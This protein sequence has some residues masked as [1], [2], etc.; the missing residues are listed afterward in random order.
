[1]LIEITAEKVRALF[2]EWWKPFAIVLLAALLLF[3]NARENAQTQARLSEVATETHSALCVF[4]QS[5]EDRIQTTEDY[6]K[7]HPGPEPIPG[8]TR[9]DLRRSLDA[10]RQTLEALS[11]LDCTDIQG[12]E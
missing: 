10:Q 3:A 9:G 1:M 6:L 8:I 5:I 4:K 2:K 7:K 11:I 12:G